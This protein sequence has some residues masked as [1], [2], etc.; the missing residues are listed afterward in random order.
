MATASAPRPR[1][2]TLSAPFCSFGLAVL[3]AAADVAVCCSTTAKLV[4]V[5]N[6]PLGSCVVSNTKLWTTPPPGVNVVMKV[7]PLA[8]VAVNVAPDTALVNTTELPAESLVE[9]V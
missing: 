2:L 9:T 7:L 5:V 6:C 3:V 8:S 4:I 1:L